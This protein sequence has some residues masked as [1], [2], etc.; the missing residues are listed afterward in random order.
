MR[1]G[2]IKAVIVGADRIAA[3]G[4]VANKIGTFGVAILARNFKIPF[5]VAAP[6]STIDL[7]LADGSQIP[8]EERSAAEIAAPP[9]VEVYNP[10]FDVTPAKW[11]NAIITENGVVR[12]PYQAGLRKVCAAN[13]P[14]PSANSGKASGAAK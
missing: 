1:Q 11:V 3:N 7:S 10:A 9:G 2:K 8:I 6:I 14:R 12:A 5:Y 13:A 4:D